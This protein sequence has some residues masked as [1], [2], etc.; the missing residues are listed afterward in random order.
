MSA[1]CERRCILSRVRS[2]GP[3][4]GSEVGSIMIVKKSLHGLKLS[5]TGFRAHMAKMLMI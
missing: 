5:G 2:A 1:V 3:E 4:F